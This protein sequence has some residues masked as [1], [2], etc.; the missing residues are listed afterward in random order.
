M[1]PIPGDADKEQEDEY[2][3][4]QLCPGQIELDIEIDPD[5]HS[6]GNAGS[7]KK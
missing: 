1:P 2:F 5:Q 4:E 6:N 3:E 7:L